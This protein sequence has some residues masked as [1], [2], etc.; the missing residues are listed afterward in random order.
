VIGFVH[1]ADSN[2]DFT[3]H[4]HNG[5][6]LT[7]RTTHVPQGRPIQGEP[8]FTWEDSARDAINMTGLKNFKD[9]DLGAI[10]QR[11]EQY[12]GFGYR[13]HNVNSP[14]LWNCSDKYEKGRFG[15]GGG[16]DPNAVAV[17][18]GAAPIIRRMMDR[19]LIVL[20]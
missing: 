16:F 19:G 3:K 5:D 18:C 20:G 6:P 13:G 7:A 10:L 14:Y 9:W 8:P 15:S 2:G 4:L 17:N 12:N 1:I 11:L